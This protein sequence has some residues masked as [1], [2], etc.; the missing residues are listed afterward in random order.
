M[1]QSTELKKVNKQKGPSKDASIPLKR[2][3]KTIMRDREET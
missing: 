2:E 1:I 3:K